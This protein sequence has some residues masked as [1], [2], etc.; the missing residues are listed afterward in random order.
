MYSKEHHAWKIVDLGLAKNGTSN[1]SLATRGGGTTLY[2][3][4]E[5]KFDSG[6]YTNKV[7]IWALGC[8][9]YEISTGERLCP[10]GSNQEE[11]VTSNTGFPRT[12]FPYY[13]DHARFLLELMRDTLA[14]ER[15][16]RPKAEKIVQRIQLHL[17]NFE[18]DSLYN[19]YS[20]ADKRWLKLD[21][22]QTLQVRCLR[23][24]KF[25]VIHEV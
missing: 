13:G 4:P 22:G 5:F 23:T 20:F 24:E 8:T 3:A 16:A 17:A 18:G 21:G 19:A 9:M 25:S 11:F 15:R 2:M 10:N 6:T 12:R 7:D 14:L 1:T